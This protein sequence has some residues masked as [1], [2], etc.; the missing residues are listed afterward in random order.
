MAST[1][2]GLEQLTDKQINIKDNYDSATA[3]SDSI[4]QRIGGR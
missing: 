2:Y 4:S 3:A 1:A